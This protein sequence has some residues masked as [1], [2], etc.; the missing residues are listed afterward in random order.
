METIK[1][2]DM[3]N[4]CMRIR[5]YFELYSDNE[6]NI[7]LYRNKTQ[8]LK[9]LITNDDLESKMFIVAIMD[10][11]GGITRVL[12]GYINELPFLEWIGTNEESFSKEY[13]VETMKNIWPEL[14]NE[15]SI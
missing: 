6:K 7:S 14:F 13:F 9:E 8:E 15:T 10:I 1:F 12:R 5:N 3:S 11:V 4:Y 2:Y